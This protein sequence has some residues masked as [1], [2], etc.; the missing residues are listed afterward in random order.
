M[1][2]PIKH[3][4]MVRALAKPGKD[5][6]A[7]MTPEGVHLLHMAVGISGEV[8][9]LLEAACA[10]PENLDMENLVEE[11]GDL[12][13]YIE[14]ARQGLGISREEVMLTRFDINLHPAVGIPVQA[15]NF[16]DAVKRLVIY[17]KPL[18][19]AKAIEALA[20]IE[21]FLRCMRED[22][23][24]TREATLDANIA[25]LGKRYEGMRYSDQAAQARADKAAA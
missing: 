24:V 9:E 18:D 5:I 25:K 4:D 14:G 6:L 12:E 10:L 20:G 19:Q 22:F 21:V 13:F 16:L 23:G 11:F 3:E 8:G 7:T 1:T 17:N 2:E 15:A